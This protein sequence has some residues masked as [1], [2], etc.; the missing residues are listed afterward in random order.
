WGVL[1]CASR[2][3]AVPACVAGYGES[4]PG[5][6]GEEGPAGPAAAP[7]WHVLWRGASRTGVAREGKLT[8][9]SPPI[10]TLH[11]ACV[12]LSAGATSPRYRPASTLF[13]SKSMRKAQ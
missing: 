6:Q 10:L 8:T 4:R 3:L 5:P 7:S 2:R 11:V 1:S 13:P 12:A 9:S